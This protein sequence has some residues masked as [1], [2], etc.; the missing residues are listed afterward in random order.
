VAYGG[1]HTIT[2]AGGG[3]RRWVGGTSPTPTSVNGKVD[4]FTFVSDGV[5]TFG[6][7]GG[8]NY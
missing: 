2:W 7:S 5:N 3:I 4:I 1:V 8:S 6:Q